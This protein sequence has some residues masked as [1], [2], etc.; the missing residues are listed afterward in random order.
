MLASVGDKNYQVELFELE[1]RLYN[2]ITHIYPITYLEPTS[3]S[4]LYLLRIIQMEEGSKK[5]VFFFRATELVCL[6]PIFV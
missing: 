4:V 6:L 5:L 2:D 1:R 3:S